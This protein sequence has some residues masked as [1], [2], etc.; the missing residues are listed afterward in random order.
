MKFFGLIWGALKRKK[1]RTALTLLSIVV[2][3]ILF[4]FLFAI[5]EA[6]TAGVKMADADRLVVR[7]KV[8]IIQSLPQS[9][10]QRIASIPGVAAVA[11]Q[12]WFGGL[13]QDSK[14]P[15]P[16]F[17]VDPEKYLNLYPEIVL[18]ADQ[19]EAWLKTRNG[20]VVGRALAA[21]RHW[22]IGDHIPLTA[23]IWGQPEGKDHWDFEVVGLYDSAK[24][25]VDPSGFFFRY[26]YFDEARPRG[27][28]Q[29]GWFTVRVNNP[30]QAPEI[31]KKIDAEFANSPYETKA[32]PEGAMAAGFAQQFGDIGKIVMAVLSAVF[33]TILLVAGN[34]MGQSVR[35]RTE[36]IGVL[37]AMGFTNEL[38]LVLVLLESCILAVLGGIAGLAFA[39]L[40]IKPIPNFLPVLYVPTKAMLLGIGVAL[41][42]GVIAGLIPAVQA[43]R[44]RIAV[45]LRRGA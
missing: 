22:K 28:G 38:V 1:L 11:G 3:F 40:V 10:E 41:G 29:I 21:E 12:S 33:F 16:S 35:E 2:A 32:E 25:S 13:Y 30:D 39:W 6:F 19:K 14:N 4:G 5:K 7:H 36:E 15:I 42:L 45:A 8:S 26:D 27:K 18:P 44:L 24:K 34:A 9:Y 37:K 31:A 43:M 17:P 23:P 20:A